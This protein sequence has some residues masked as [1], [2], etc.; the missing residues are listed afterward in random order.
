MWSIEGNIPF[1]WHLQNSIF[2]QKR[3]SR[4]KQFVIFDGKSVWKG[5]FKQDKAKELSKRFDQVEEWNLPLAVLPEAKFYSSS[6]IEGLFLHYEN[7]SE[8]YS[9]GS[10]WHQESFSEF[11][12]QVNRRSNLVKI[13]DV[14][15]KKVNEWIYDF[16]PQ[17]T[18][19]LCALT[20]IGVGD[21]HTCNILA[22]LEKR[23][24]YI[25][26]FDQNRSVEP[27]GDFFFLSKAPA[28]NIATKWKEELILH[29]EEIIQFIKNLEITSELED[30]RKSILE[31]LKNINYVKTNRVETSSRGLMIYSGPFNSRTYSNL[32][33]D[34]AKSGLQ[35]YI[36]R[37]EV[38]NAL[39]M[40]FELLR[41]RELEAKSIVSNLSNRL[42]I[43]AVEDI[44]PANCDLVEKVLQK[45]ISD[46]TDEEV[47]NLVVEMCNS[48]KT[49]LLSHLARAYHT[50]YRKISRKYG[51]KV[52]VESHESDSLDDMEFWFLEDEEEIREIGNIFLQRLR[53]KSINAFTWAQYYH[54]KFDDVKIKARGRRRKASVV[55][56]RMME[57]EI[58][59]NNLSLFRLL[60]KHFFELTENKPFLRMALYL[61]LKGKVEAGS[62]DCKEPTLSLNELLTGQY[63]VVVKDYV[64]DQHTAEGKRRGS[65]RKMFTTQGAF[66]NNEDL[67]FRDETLLKIYG[68]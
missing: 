43:I 18:M 23:Q 44:G 64:I 55:L 35:K 1:E 8:N 53:E 67:R 39:M 10:D 63:E 27:E 52:E 4:N 68:E 32:S 13:S 50:K 28:K 11:S 56:W 58:D 47:F 40:T 5:P 7:L 62:S 17:M 21:L 59:K 22:D 54:E 60:E 6:D 12:Y 14:L 26:D 42:A 29:K 51:I 30:R 2:G 34:I 46:R 9:S 45:H 37:G 36:R 25:I 41:M 3:T 16:V 31:A 66:V 49:R 24:V 48:A 65:D 38:D 57:S 15:Q 61:T 20:L 33:I 19:T